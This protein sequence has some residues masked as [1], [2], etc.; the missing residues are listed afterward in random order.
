VAFLEKQ[1]YLKKSQLPNSGKG[2]F[3]RKEIKKGTRIVEYKGRLCEWNKV[4]HLDGHNPYIFKINSKWAVDAKTHIKSFGRYANDAKGFSRIKEL[5]N[6][7][8][9]EVVGKRVFI[10]A[11]R[12]IKKGEEIL[13]EYG[14]NFW[15]L[16][17]KISKDKAK[18][19]VK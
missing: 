19:K 3:I 16:L 10:D 15:S 11:V 17:R 12:S 6:N 14:G 18:Q 7:A 4:K 13:V 9:Y 8:E 5:K 1:L 2:L